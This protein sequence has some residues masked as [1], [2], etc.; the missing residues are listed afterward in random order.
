[1]TI[2]TRY[3]LFITLVLAVF[4]LSMT[5]YAAQMTA[6]RNI[7]RVCNSICAVDARACYE[8]DTPLNLCLDCNTQ[9]PANLDYCETCQAPLA[10]MRVLA[11]IAPEVREQ[12]RLDQ[13]KRAVIDKELGKVDYRLKTGT[14]DR[15]DL[16]FTKAK[17]LN[18]MKFYSRESEAWRAFL[19]EFPNSDQ[20]SYAEASLSEA[21][22]KW[23]YLLYTQKNITAAT[24]LLHD[25]TQTNPTNS[26]AWRWLGRLQ[27]ESGEREHAAESYLQ[28]LKAEPGNR[29]SISILRSMKVDIPKELLKAGVK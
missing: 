17:L 21:L 12:L 10:N 22:R 9:N 1:M 28:S 13:S 25:A 27:R 19:N 8:C 4:F 5:V 7:C 14:G 20:S 24:E 26:L 11:S 2:T 15:E 16:L 18:M 29:N 3:K 6:G 23:A